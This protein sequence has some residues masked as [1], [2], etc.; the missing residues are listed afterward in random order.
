MYSDND[1]SVFSSD[2]FFMLD[3]FS[4]WFGGGGGME[5][6]LGN[7]Q[8]CFSI[9]FRL[10][11]VRAHLSIKD[12]YHKCLQGIN[13]KWQ[14][15]KLFI[16]WWNCWVFRQGGAPPGVIALYLLSWR[17]HFLLLGMIYSFFNLKVLRPFCRPKFWSCVDLLSFNPNPMGGGAFISPSPCSFFRAC[18]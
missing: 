6:P 17:N 3:I 2:I 18:I 10:E 13:R 11:E 12:K 4:L 8:V 14:I 1:N 16:F 7:W 5:L 15:W 9:I